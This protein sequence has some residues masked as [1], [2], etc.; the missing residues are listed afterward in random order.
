[1]ITLKGIGFATVMDK[2]SE[3]GDE[4]SEIGGSFVLE[5]VERGVEEPRMVRKD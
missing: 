1:M 5:L 4:M 2:G 3:V